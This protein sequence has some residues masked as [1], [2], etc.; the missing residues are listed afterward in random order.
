MR[1]SG[2]LTAWKAEQGDPEQGAPKVKF[3]SSEDIENLAAQGQKELILDGTIALTDLARDVA[4]QLGIT[5][6]DRSTAVATS[7]PST[8]S[9][10]SRA[11]APN[12]PPAAAGES[13]AA[14]SRP[15]ASGE[16]RT[17]TAQLPAKPKGCQHGPLTSNPPAQMATS[18]GSAPIVDRL[19]VMVKQIAKR[20]G[21]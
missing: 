16:S 17:P 10:E 6:T 15:A 13:P 21:N 8:S 1:R 20:P 11:A 19:V 4:R 7:R 18:G 2:R 12:R 5:L 9:G 14:S 3:Y